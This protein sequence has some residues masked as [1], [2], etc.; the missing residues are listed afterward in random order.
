MSRILALIGLAY[1]LAPLLG[2]AS[3]RG[4]HLPAAAD[5]ASTADDAHARGVPIVLMVSSTA[6]AYCARLRTE[7]FGPM[8]RF[9]P[10]AERVSFIELLLDVD[11]EILDFDG[12]PVSS[13]VLS[14]RYDAVLTPTVLF[15]APDGTE[16][17][18]RMVGVQN[19]DFYP[20]YFDQ[21][22]ELATERLK[23]VLDN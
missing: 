11:E 5:L 12:R 15:L 3:E 22:V 10:D 17:A 21:R 18:E 23:H 6:C 9:K 2:G 14:R 1:C 4:E 7:V 19:F 8:L 13:G 16:L 20:W